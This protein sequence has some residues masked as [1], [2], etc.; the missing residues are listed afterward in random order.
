MLLILPHHSSQLLLKVKN[1]V[2][3]LPY[4][5]LSHFMSVYLVNSLWSEFS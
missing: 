5:H 4:W 1:T 2:V 3:I